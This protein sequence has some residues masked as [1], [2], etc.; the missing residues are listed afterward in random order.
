M[1]DAH[2]ESESRDEMNGSDNTE[3]QDFAQET[4]FSGITGSSHQEQLTQFMKLYMPGIQ[5]IDERGPELRYLVP[6]NQPQ[7]LAE[8]LDQLDYNLAALG[9]TSYGLSACSMEQVF[10]SL[11]EER[12]DVSTDGE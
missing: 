4:P 12:E 11:N 3:S 6:L 5:F 10:V 7:L 9:L 1:V 8:L 2:S